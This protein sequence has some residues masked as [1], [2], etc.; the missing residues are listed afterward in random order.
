MNN[1]RSQDISGRRR[2]HIRSPTGQFV[3][4]RDRD[5]VWFEALWR[6][7]PLSSSFLHAFTE[8]VWSSAQ[9]ADRRLTQL[10]HETNSLHGGPYLDRPAQQFK[11]LDACCNELIYELNHHSLK[12]LKDND[13]GFSP[14]THPTG[15][16]HHRYMV[17]TITAS[18]E[19]ATCTMPGLRYVPQ[20]EILARAGTGLRAQVVIK[21]RQANREERHDLIPDALFGLE[22]ELGGGNGYRFF[23]LEADRGTEP[24]STNRFDRKSYLRTLLQYQEFVG[25]GHYKKHFGMKAPML[26]LHATISESRQVNMLKLTSDSAQNGRNSYHCFTSLQGFGAILRPPKAPLDLLTRPWLRAGYAPL[27]L[28]EAK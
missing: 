2:R 8:T 24:I 3:R 20:H 28:A 14:S 9:G 22:Y 12:A 18:I 4:A 5:L 27:I 17:A 7:G 25:R 19:L 23:A 10:F 6:H 13:F 21:N 16:W 11:T 26:V 1:S 15:P